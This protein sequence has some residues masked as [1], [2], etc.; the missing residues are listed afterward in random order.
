[1]REDPLRID[2]VEWIKKNAIALDTVE[3]NDNFSDLQPLK[4][5]LKDVQI[6]G[7]GEATHGTREF[8]TLKHRLIKFLVTELEFDTLAF[9]TPSI[10]S[11]NAWVRGADIDGRDALRGQS[12]LV[13]QTQEIFNLIEWMREFNLRGE[14]RVIDFVGIDCQISEQMVV[15]VIARLRATG[16][17]TEEMDA[18]QSS[19]HSLF[20]KTSPLDLQSTSAEIV[21]KLSLLKATAGA[22]GNSNCE[23]QQLM[24]ILV[25]GAELFALRADRRSYSRVRDRLMAENAARLVREGRKV[26]VWAH[27]GHV[28]RSYP[29]SRKTMGA[30]LNDY[31]AQ[32]YYAV[33]F[34]FFKG[35]FSSNQRRLGESPEYCIARS[36]NEHIE[37]LFHRIKQPRLFVDIRTVDG[38]SDVKRWWSLPQKMQGAG[39]NFNEQRGLA[40]YLVSTETYDGLIYLETTSSSRPLTE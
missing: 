14:H 30:Y 35:V 21:L 8:F 3:P 7:L 11:I 29:P 25:Q 19:F 1:M 24:E 20:S 22:P 33:G 2:V 13:W 17:G 15:E 39:A 12:F 26:I 5:I 31:F 37:S 32:N 9:E 23:T 38:T 40:T 34:C 10:G 6:V 28:S 16:L 4:D 36:P 27:N 18:L